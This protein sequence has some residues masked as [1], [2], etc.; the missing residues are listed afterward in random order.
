MLALGLGALPLCNFSLETLVDTLQ[1][2]RTLGDT[3]F[4]FLIGAGQSRVCPKQLNEHPN[5]G[6][7]HWSDDGREDEVHRTELISP[8][9]LH[10]VRIR[11]DKD[12]GCMATIAML[13]DQ[14]RRL[15]AI[16]VR[17]I[18]VEQN[19]RE[20][21]VQDSLQRFRAGAR[22]DDMC[23]DLLEQRAV[24]QP[25]LRQVV[26]DENLRAGHH[27]SITHTSRSDKWINASVAVLRARPPQR[28]R[29]GSPQCVAA[30]AYKA[31]QFRGAWPP[32]RTTRSCF[33]VRP[34]PSVPL[35]T[36]SS[37]SPFCARSAM[38]VLTSAS[39]AVNST[40]KPST[41]GSSTRPPVRTT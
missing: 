14:T 21:G 37:S 38:N 10:L 31:R 13:A 1:L 12:D 18:D 40:T 16:D 33:A 39:L 34:I 11:R 30:I 32:Q 26:D 24:H 36:T 5:L 25:L 15:E 6:A 9:R 35:R 27:P 7:Q 28:T 20:F 19:H 23:V 4:E 3:R 17:H 8:R 2:A 29:P 41:A 22:D